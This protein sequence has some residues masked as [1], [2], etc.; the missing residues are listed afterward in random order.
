MTNC[1]FEDNFSQVTAGAISATNVTLHVQETTFVGNK[2]EDAGV[3]LAI[4]TDTM[5][6]EKNKLC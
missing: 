6:I 4:L 3:I 5:Q 2:A 1:T